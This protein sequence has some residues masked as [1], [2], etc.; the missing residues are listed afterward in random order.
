[1][2]SLTLCLHT[3]GSDLQKGLKELDEKIKKAKV[4]VREERITYDMKK[5]EVEQKLAD[6][7]V[8]CS[9]TLT[10]AAAESDKIMILSAFIERC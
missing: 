7:K 1:M 8:N 5:Q 6:L 10:A 3:Q 4:S 9:A 2:S